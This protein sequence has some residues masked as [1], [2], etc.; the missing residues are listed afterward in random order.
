MEF[1]ISQ[2]VIRNLYGFVD[3]GKKMKKKKATKRGRNRYA[4]REAQL[5][6]R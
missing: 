3:F 5:Q 4:P 2:S 6:A 1:S